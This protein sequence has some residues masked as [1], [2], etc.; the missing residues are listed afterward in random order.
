MSLHPYSTYLPPYLHMYHYL[1]TTNYVPTY[2]PDNLTYLPTYLT[3]LPTY[4]PNYLPT[5]LTFVRMYL[6]SVRN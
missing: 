3:T 1:L 4:L 6:R 2:L 5:Y